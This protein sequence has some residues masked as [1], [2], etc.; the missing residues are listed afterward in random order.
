[1]MSLYKFMIGQKVRVDSGWKW[2]SW[3][4]PKEIIG[5]SVM[6]GQPMYTLEGEDEPIHE[7]SL[8]ELDDE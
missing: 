5:R 2:F 1:M 8:E 6:T 7:D 3:S 4:E